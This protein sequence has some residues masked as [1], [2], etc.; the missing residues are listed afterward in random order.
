[1]S[2]VTWRAPDE[3]VERVRQAAKQQGR[4]LNDY[5]TR[6]AEA[7]TDPDLADNDAQRLRERLA[8]AGL[9]VE[10]GGPR[11]RPDPAALARARRAAARGTALSELIGEER[12]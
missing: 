7:A 3:L 4:S 6:V 1:M 8:R 11:R 2:Q 9:L 10:P 12:D 5:L